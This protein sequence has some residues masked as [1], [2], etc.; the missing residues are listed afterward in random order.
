MKTFNKLIIAL[1]L[2]L[3]SLTMNA[4]Q[5][6][7]YTHYM[8][9]TLVVN[10]GYAGSRDALTV[11][12]LYR[13]Q[14]AGFEG[15]PKTET[16]TLHSPVGDNM[17]LGL[18]VNNDKI[19]PVNNT[20]VFVD[21]A[22]KLKLTELA[23]LAFGLSGGVNM[24]QANLSSLKIDQQND[25]AFQNDVNNHVTPNFGFGAYY[26]RERFY[27]GVSIPN[28]IE[29]NLSGVNVGNGT[30]LTGVEQRHYFFIAGSMIPL[31]NNFDFKP[32]TLIKVTQAAPVEADFTA[33]FIINKRLLLGAMFRTGDAF[34]ALVGLDITEQLHIGYSYDFSFGLKTGTYNNGSHEIILRYDFLVRD[35]KQIHSPRYF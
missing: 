17:G 29:S 11:T 3:S 1:V 25:A 21:F 23:K 15:A 35:N 26:S 27:A 24:F 9:N 20:S 8:Y 13:N 32:T 34:G 14:W 31:A 28:L 22:Y 30:N 7:M 16:L 10:P 5:L 33:S 4:Q 2:A 18:S 6:P 19:G 12:G